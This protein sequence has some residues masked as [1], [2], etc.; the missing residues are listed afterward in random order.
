MRSVN[1]T[2]A[3]WIC[4]LAWLL[5]AAQTPARAGEV[6]PFPTLEEVIASRSDLWGQLALE[7]TN[8]LTYEFF[9]SVLPPPRYVNA[10]FREYPIV[11]SAPRA[12]VKARLIS[13]G[14]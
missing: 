2:L 6:T 12:L 8:G 1:P 3:K 11:L 10:D 13:N 9:A 14:S 4:A 5:L 7:N